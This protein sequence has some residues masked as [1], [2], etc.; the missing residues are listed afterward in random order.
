M[1]YNKTIFMTTLC[2]LLM[3]NELFCCNY[4]DIKVRVESNIKSIEF[5]FEQYE[6]DGYDHNINFDYH[7]GYLRGKS[8]AYKEI[9]AMLQD[10]I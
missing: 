5:I 10:S 3:T 1:K 4:E 2:A 8:N 9:R 6:L 7:V